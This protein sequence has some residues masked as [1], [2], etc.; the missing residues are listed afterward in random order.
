M[1]P[2]G[3]EGDVDEDAGLVG[4]RAAP[5]VDADAHNHLALSLL[6]DQRTPVIPLQAGQADRQTDRK[7]KQFGGDQKLI[8]VF[9]K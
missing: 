2:L 7:G 6:A 3:V 8:A 9:F 5:A 1:D 4:S